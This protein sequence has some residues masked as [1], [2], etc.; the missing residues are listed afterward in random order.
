VHKS[1]TLLD[2]LGLAVRTRDGKTLL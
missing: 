2:R 1:L